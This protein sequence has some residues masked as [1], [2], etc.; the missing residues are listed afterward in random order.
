MNLYYYKKVLSVYVSFKKESKNYTAIV[1]FVG[2]NVD[3][4]KG[5]VI[6]F[7]ILDDYYEPYRLRKDKNRPN[8]EITVNNTFKNIQESIKISELY[9]K[10]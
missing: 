2:E 9:L 10:E 8:G 3:L 7:K 1:D 6:E 5:A 4:L